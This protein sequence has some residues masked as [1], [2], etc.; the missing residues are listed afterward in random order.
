MC[1]AEALYVA[2]V[3]TSCILVAPQGESFAAQ[4][5]RC[6]RV[7]LESH[8][9]IINIWKQRIGSVAPI[10]SDMMD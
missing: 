4:D 10:S 3:A 2:M 9:A 7:H 8:E 5:L 1:A 6:T